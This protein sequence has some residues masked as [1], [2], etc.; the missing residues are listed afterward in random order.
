VL[1]MM[2]MPGETLH[3]AVAIPPEQPPGLYWYHTHPHGESQR[4]ALD[5]MSGAIVVDGIDRYV[6]DV[7]RLPE[8][9]IVIRGRDIEHAPEAA[10]LRRRVGVSDAPCGTATEMEPS[11]RIMTL[12]GVVRPGIPIAPGERQF[13]R[14]VNAGADTY[15]DMQIDGQPLEIVALDGMPLDY[16]DTAQRSR[17]MDHRLV[18]PGGRIELIVTGPP[19]GARATLRTRCVDTGPAGDPSPA[20]VLA[21]LVP[22][23]LSLPPDPPGRARSCSRNRTGPWFQSRATPTVFRSG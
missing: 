3:Y 12:N 16:Y 8:R 7:R 20:M 19:K 18:P 15:I 23:H 14:I 2:A 17:R 10:S 1:D 13:W 21:D 5:G 22:V 11:E 9:V 4:Q 6:P